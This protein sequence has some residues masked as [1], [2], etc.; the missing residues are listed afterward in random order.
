MVQHIL[1]ADVCLLLVLHNPQNIDPPVLCLTSCKSLNKMYLFHLNKSWI[2]CPTCSRTLS[3]SDCEAFFPPWLFFQSFNWSVWF[4]KLDRNSGFRIPCMYDSSKA[5]AWYH[6]KK[7]WTSQIVIEKF[8]WGVGRFF[9]SKIREVFIALKLDCEEILAG[10][11]SADRWRARDEA[12]INYQKLVKTE[13]E[14]SSCVNITQR[15]I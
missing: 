9:R 2:G 13:S 1:Q 4:S 12:L 15:V 5:P 11:L 10:L 14:L 7:K 3:R 8:T 6:K